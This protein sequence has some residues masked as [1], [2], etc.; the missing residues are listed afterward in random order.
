[1]RGQADVAALV[2]TIAGKS[3][4][5]PGSL[6]ARLVDPV[7]PSPADWQALA[8][9][10]VPRKTRLSFGVGT[11]DTPVSGSDLIPSILA[12]AAATGE[13]TPGLQLI[14]ALWQRHVHDTP[15]AH[16][17]FRFGAPGGVGNRPDTINDVPYFDVRVLRLTRETVPVPLTQE[18]VRR[19]LSWLHH[20]RV[21]GLEA[22]PNGLQFDHPLAGDLFEGS[23]LDIVSRASEQKAQGR[24]QGHSGR[25][26]QRR[27]DQAI[28]EVYAATEAEPAA[29][30]LSSAQ[31][32]SDAN[33]RIKQMPDGSPGLIIVPAV[34][35][36]GK[37][38]KD[39]VQSFAALTKP[40]PLRGHEVLRWML[41]IPAPPTVLED[42]Q[43]ILANQ[44][45][46]DVQRSE[47]PQSDLTATQ[48]ATMLLETLLE[49]HCPGFGEIITDIV[50]EA[51][52]ALHL[53]QPWLQLR[54]RLLV[55]PPGCGKTHF[56]QVLGQISGCGSAL[57]NAGGSIDNRMLAGTARGWHSAQPCWPLL[58]M[59]QLR[60]AN[61]VLIVDE[62]DKVSKETRNG[63]LHDTLLAMLEPSSAGHY[64]D[65]C[66]LA[67]ADLRS[68]NW[69]FTAN[70]VAL[71]PDALRSRL[72]VYHIAPTS[73]PIP[74]ALI[75]QLLGDIARDHQ[76]RLEDLPELSSDVRAAITQMPQRDTRRLQS[77]LRQCLAL[78]A[79]KQAQENQGGASNAM[80]RLH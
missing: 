14:K 22:L 32:N 73:G 11:Q 30:A 66:L 20:C 64:Q 18:M 31:A 47:G 38:S 2:L 12:L 3:G 70:D 29:A 48:S 24:L 61:P 68:I 60:S 26:M 54:P 35:D 74:E 41:G 28:E 25:T 44:Y 59:R 15:N 75:D 53:G 58:M 37:E 17:L 49:L 5:V 13:P 8:R 40:L 6:L 77:A 1:M 52:L 21:D 65:E 67:A 79:A 19:I 72:K 55:G 76:V 33:G 7:F 50:Q 23:W 45:I 4:R 36:T 63:N 57:F 78:E 80:H 27:E 71:I 42:Q 69:I 9:C 51:S 16:R 56:A 62:I 46:L 39:I 43:A 34:L 10:F